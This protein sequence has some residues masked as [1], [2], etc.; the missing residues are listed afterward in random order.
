MIPVRCP[1][2][3]CAAASAAHIVV[4]H[5]LQDDIDAALDAG[6]LDADACPHCAPHCREQV[7]LARDARRNALAARERFRMRAERLARRA[8][9]RDAARAVRADAAAVSAP[10][11]PPAAAAALQRALAR[12]KGRAR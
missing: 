4:G 7:I 12:A 10:A 6:L 9:E 8:A 2:C 3:A 1:G 5:V 11:I